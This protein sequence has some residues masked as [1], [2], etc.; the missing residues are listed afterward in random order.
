MHHLSQ[1]PQ[2]SLPQSLPQSQQ[3]QQQQQQQQSQYGSFS[4]GSSANAHQPQQ[5]VAHPGVGNGSAGIAPQD[6]THQPHQ[7]QPG[8]VISSSGPL[9]ATGDWTKDLVQLAK[10]AELKYVFFWIWIFIFRLE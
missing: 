3:Q 9:V 4:A 2:Q 1:H 6:T 7:S 8:N 5:L 10:T